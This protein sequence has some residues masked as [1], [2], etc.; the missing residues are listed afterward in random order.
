MKLR[1]FPDFIEFNN[2]RQAQGFSRVPWQEFLRIRKLESERA[3][4]RC[5]LIGPNPC[6]GPVEAREAQ[7]LLPR[8]PTETT[9]EAP[10]R[11]PEAVSE[12]VLELTPDMAVMEP[13][14]SPGLAELNN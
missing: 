14:E 10:V 6:T 8:Q 5:M 7:R 1:G 11:A 2:K 4:G 3:K 13:L 9:P 12:G